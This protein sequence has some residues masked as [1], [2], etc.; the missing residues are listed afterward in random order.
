M[1]IFNSF[2]THTHFHV[3]KSI[4][5]NS[6]YFFFNSCQGKVCPAVNDELGYW[7]FVARPAHPSKDLIVFDEGKKELDELGAVG[8]GY[9]VEHLGHKVPAAKRKF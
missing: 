5:Q 3:N 1:Y 8:R 2:S 7:V 6:L 9:R 4:I